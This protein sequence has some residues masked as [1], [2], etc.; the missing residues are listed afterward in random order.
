MHLF[1]PIFYYIIIKEGFKNA[2]TDI[3]FSMF[4]LLVK[5]C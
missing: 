3:Q 5:Q 4:N 2:L 1:N